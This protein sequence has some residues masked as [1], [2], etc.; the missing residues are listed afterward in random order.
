DLCLD[1]VMCSIN[2]PIIF[3][4]MQHNGKKYIDGAFGNPYPVD[5][6][7]NG[8]HNV[9]G[10]FMKSTAHDDNISDYLSTIVDS[11]LYQRV[12]DIIQKSS[13]KCR[14]IILETHCSG[15]IGYNLTSHDKTEMLIFGHKK[16]K[17]YIE[18]YV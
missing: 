4:E 13:D 11:I 6:F 16:G 1:V 15:F 17:E 10:I 3:Y 2:I 9:L 12:S 7:D 18:N 5:Y 14:H 8:E